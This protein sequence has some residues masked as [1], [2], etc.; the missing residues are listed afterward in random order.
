MA[1]CNSQRG[2]WQKYIVA[3]REKGQHT[4]AEWQAMKRFYHFHCVRCQQRPDWRTTRLTKDHVI[5]IS[6]GGDDSITN[7]QPLCPK[8]NS[9]KGTKT[10][11]YRQTWPEKPLLLFYAS[12]IGGV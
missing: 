7:L 4:R 5:P 12:L 1:A 3:A 2:N 6:E 11:D 9:R 10:K 8:C